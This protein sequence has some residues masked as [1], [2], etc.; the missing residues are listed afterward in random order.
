MILETDHDY[1]MRRARA[2]L[3]LACRSECRAAKESH[4]RLSSLHMRRLRGLQPARKPAGVSPFRPPER[5]IEAR[6]VGT[7]SG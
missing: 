2:E 1:H 3:D 5:H 6:E 4:L 7:V